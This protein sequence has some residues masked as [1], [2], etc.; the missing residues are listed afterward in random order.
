MKMYK[1]Q[2]R[3]SVYARVCALF[4]FCQSA[5]TETRDEKERKKNEPQYYNN[6]NIKSDRKIHKICL[7]SGEKKK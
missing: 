6:N 1:L 2:V 4:P 7:L 5:K 3:F